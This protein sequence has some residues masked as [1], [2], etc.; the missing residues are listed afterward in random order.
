MKKLLKKKYFLVPLI[1]IAALG[2]CAG[3]VYA[4]TALTFPGQVNVVA[5][6]NDI[7]VYSDPDCKFELTA[8]QW[9]DLPVGG[10]SIKTV[11]VKDIGNTDAS[12]TAT[13]QGAPD[14]VALK[15]GTNT[16]QIK[17]GTSDQ[18]DLILEANQSAALA[19]LS[20]SVVFNSTPV[21]VNPYPIFVNK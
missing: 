4:A 7:K 17:A 13:L 15:S 18:F 8:L 3:A 21:F 16:V 20:F 1:T 14:G 10:E 19:A 9:T 6:T 12:V 5:A 2:V 11:Y